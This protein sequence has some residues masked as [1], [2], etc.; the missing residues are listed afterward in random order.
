VRLAEPLSSVE[1]LPSSQHLPRAERLSSFG[2]YPVME[3]PPAVEPLSPMRAVPPVHMAASLE[4]LLAVQ[5]QL[6]AAAPDSLLAAAPEPLLVAVPETAVAP[7]PEQREIAAPEPLVA[8]AAATAP[9]AAELVCVCT[10]FFP[11]TDDPDVEKERWMIVRTFI[12]AM[13]A[14]PVLNVFGGCNLIDVEV[15]ARALIDAVPSAVWIQLAPAVT[16]VVFVWQFLL[17]VRKAM[18][19]SPSL[20]QAVGELILFCIT[21]EEQTMPRWEAK[22][23]R[24]SKDYRNMWEDGEAASYQSWLLS[25]GIEPAVSHVVSGEASRAR[26]QVQAEEERTGQAWPGRATLRAFPEDSTAERKRAKAA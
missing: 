24:S 14:E 4:P 21:A 11:E 6:S 10:D 7:V 26:V 17:L 12:A 13:L 9:V 2:P 19:E 23:G 15:L 16:P 25:L 5:E 22:A 1:P 8:A 18:D 3:V 20:C